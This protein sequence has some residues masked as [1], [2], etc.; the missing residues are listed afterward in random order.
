VSA[1]NWPN[2]N[3]YNIQPTFQVVTQNYGQAFY[4]SLDQDGFLSSN[5]L[6]VSNSAT[7]T[8][9]ITGLTTAGFTPGGQ[10]LV[11][12]A[13]MLAVSNGTTWNPLSDGLQHLL[14]YLNGAWQ[15]IA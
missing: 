12:T 9:T 3:F 14:V 7:G 1:T 10:P 13:G 5:G 15:K 2:V 11:P 8:V 6:I 4:E